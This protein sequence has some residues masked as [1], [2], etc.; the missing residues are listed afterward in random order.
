MSNFLGGCHFSVLSLSEFCFK[1]CALK[2]AWS[3]L[4]YPAFEVVI[5]RLWK[6]DALKKCNVCPWLVITLRSAQWGLG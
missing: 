5:S 6:I 4:F 1:L 3:S 2:A